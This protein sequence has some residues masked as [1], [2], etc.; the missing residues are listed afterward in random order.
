LLALFD[1][2]IAFDSASKL[3]A[4]HTLRAERSPAS[5]K[6]CSH[7]RFLVPFRGNSVAFRVCRVFRGYSL[8]L[9]AAALPRCVFALKPVCIVTD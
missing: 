1:Q 3:D 7:S 5:P 6:Q 9:L 4:L 2:L 8:P